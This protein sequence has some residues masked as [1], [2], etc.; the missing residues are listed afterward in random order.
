MQYKFSKAADAA[1]RKKL[2]HQFGGEAGEVQRPYTFAKRVKTQI[3]RR[4]AGEKLARRSK[5]AKMRS[6]Y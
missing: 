4:E 1:T 2:K 5:I 3:D 6:G